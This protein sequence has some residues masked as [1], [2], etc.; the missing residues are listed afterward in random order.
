M[1]IGMIRHRRN[2]W[3]RTSRQ[4]AL[5]ACAVLIGVVL[6]AAAQGQTQPQ[7]SWIGD[8]PIPAGAQVDPA[9]SMSFDVAD[10]RVATLVLAPVAPVDVAVL[11]QFYRAALPQLGWRDSGGGGFLRGEELLRLK[12]AA[13]ALSITI[14]PVSTDP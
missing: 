9:R 6:N 4:L 8:L 14:A 12:P 13:G 1:S 2:S 10:G 11:A 3:W 5:A 7:Q